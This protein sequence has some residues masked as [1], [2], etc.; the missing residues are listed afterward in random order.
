[1]REIISA[2]LPFKRD[3]WSRE[4]ALEYF[5]AKNQPYKVEIIEALPDAEVG[6]YEQGQFLDLC[7]GPHVENTGQV[8]PIKLMSVAGA[9]WRG[10][11]ERPMLQRIYGTAWESQQDLD[12]HLWRLEEAQKRD[13]RKIGKELELFHF[14]QTAPGMPY[15]LPRGLKILHTLIDFWRDEHERH[16]YQ[17]VSTPIIN[18][19]KIWHLSGHQSH[20]QDN[21][22]MIDIDE[23]TKY[24]VKP[25]N[26]PNAMLIYNLKKRSY[27][28]L[29]LRLSDGSVLHRHEKSGVLHGLLRVQ[30]FMQDDAHIF[31]REDQIE[32]E[33][34][35]IFSI[36][37]RFYAIFGLNYSLC[38]ETRPDD[39]MGDLATWTYAEAM[40]KNVL[41]KHAGPGNYSIAEGDGAFYAPKIAI[42]MQDTLGRVWGMGTIQLDF[43]TPRRFSCV[44]IDRDG[45]EKSPVVLHKAIYGSLE[46]FIGILIEHFAGALPVWIAPVQA[47]IIPISDRHINYARHVREV[48]RDAGV[49]VEID[50]R[51]ERM[52]NKIRDAQ[53]QKIPYML[54]VGDKE[55]EASAVSLRLRSN[56][57]RGLM[58]LMQFVAQARQVI[59]SK[60]L[61]L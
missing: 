19:S 50:I 1:M 6:I 31:L 17:E 44:Y 43:Q 53:L 11:A 48:L 15:W 34:A 14:D 30:K 8:G 37:D 4:K 24:G 52:N 40:L 54:V 51:S 29:P 47:M 56:E 36:V 18:D 9:Y 23:H 55:A 38:L 20:Y 46:R 21:M 58:P 22:F 7:R 35:S 59:Q 61:Q 26:C 49:R 13:H 39:Y 10:D 12:A 28:E 16:D 32:Q 2:R 57:N 5:R 27:R 45:Q 60:S 33:I 42:N 25:M 41:D 3:R